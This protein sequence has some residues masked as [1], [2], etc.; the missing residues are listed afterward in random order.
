M[1]S[2]WPDR[3]PWATLRGRLTL[4]NTAVVLFMIG[5]ALAAVRFGAH[6]ALYGQADAV[7]RGEVQAVTLALSER[8]PDIDMVIAELRRRSIS[9][10]DRG[11]FSHLLREDGGTLWRSDRC[12]DAVAA[13]PPSR[14]DLAE[15]VVQ[16][17]DYRYVR[18]RVPSPTG[19]PFHLRIGMSTAS[20]DAGVA[21]LL[22]LVAGVGATLALLPP[23]AGW[24]LAV[25]ATEPV[26]NMLR[27]ADSLKPTRL[28]DR[29]EVRGAHD[30]LDRLA[31]TI[32]RLLDQVAD[33]VDRQQQFV[34]DAAHEL[35]GPLAA[36]RAALE[37]A[38]SRDR[39]AHDYRE[40]LTEVLE[41]TRS[42]TKLANALLTLAAT[43]AETRAV[44][45]M[46]VDVS[47]LGR[48]AAAMFAGVAEERGLG[49]VVAAED[50]ATV[51]G[52]PAQLRQILGNLLDNA[53]R[54][55]PAGGS[56]R[57]EVSRPNASFE[58][59][60]TIADSGSGIPPEHLARVFD[61]FA[62]VDK[63]RTR[64]A[65]GRTGG[66]GLAICKAIVEAHGGRIALDSWPGRGTTV[67]VHLP[68]ATAALSPAPA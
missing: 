19:A 42:L 50:G 67:T 46:P 6:G 51:P 55:T 3:G 47:A 38:I 40:T 18:R 41:E 34:A 53:M 28:G 63:A 22:R 16:V 15:N 45:R 58:V 2:P 48:Q 57:L 60:I 37:V 27:T 12:P 14:T 23:L 56:V 52:D 30:E 4:W 26:R 13:Y 32:N 59:V 66:L 35:R 44:V 5:G 21:A 33:H 65:G 49:L 61:R 25:R 54:F 36:M 10:A 62:K 43:G 11:W 39:D 1:P 24:A 8:E 17:G 20:L 64:D 68:M 29:L 7:L 31:V 9:H